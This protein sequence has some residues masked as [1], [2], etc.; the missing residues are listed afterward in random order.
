MA[1]RLE[2]IKARLAAATPGPWG[3]DTQLGIDDP[4]SADTALVVHAPEDI[5]W[6]VARV[7]RLEW[8]LRDIINRDSDE[9][10]ARAALAGQESADATL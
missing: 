3:L 4:A 1:T 9:T 8:A 10:I 2:K 5:A 7:E 6:L